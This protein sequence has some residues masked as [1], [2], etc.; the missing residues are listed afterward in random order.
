MP[1]ARPRA[2]ITFWVS[3]YSLAWGGCRELADGALHP[4]GLAI[5]LLRGD[6][7]VVGRLRLQALHAHAERR[8]WVTLVQPDGIFRRLAQILRIGAV[9]HDAVM[10]V[11]PPR[12]VGRP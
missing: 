12:V 7:I 5:A 6:P 3:R 11:R 8:V 2:S 9:V 4:I 1:G 10:H